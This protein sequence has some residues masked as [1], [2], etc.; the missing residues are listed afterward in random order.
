MTSEENK[1]LLR[2]LRKFRDGTTIPDFFNYFTL[3]LICW[4]E[5]EDE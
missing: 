4:L 3:E 1:E 2:L 5:E